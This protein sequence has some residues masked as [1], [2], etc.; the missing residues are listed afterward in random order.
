MKTTKHLVL[1]M[2]FFCYLKGVYAQENKLLNSDWIDKNKGSDSWGAITLYKSFGGLPDSNYYMNM[3]TLLMES[4]INKS[5]PGQGKRWTPTGF[6]KKVTTDSLIIFNPNG[7]GTIRFYN[8][9]KFTEST[10][11]PTRISLKG[12]CWFGAFSKIKIELNKEGKAYLAGES[13]SGTQMSYFETAITPEMFE[14]FSDMVRKTKPTSMEKFYQCACVT[15]LTWRIVI[16]Y[17]GKQKQVMVYGYDEAPPALR[18]LI[19][20]LIAAS[21]KLPFA[22]AKEG[23][24]FV[25]FEF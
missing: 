3:D 18:N 19:S 14:Y 17:N 20:S 10:A 5:K 15:A 4:Y 16:D 25:G 6:V 2:L 12:D 13:K 7:G 23:H 22:P 11:M 24:E 21:V 9:A 1:T 8:A